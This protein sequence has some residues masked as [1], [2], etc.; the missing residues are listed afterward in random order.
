MSIFLLY[1]DDGPPGDLGEP[2]SQLKLSRVATTVRRSGRP[3]TKTV[4]VISDGIASDGIR[5]GTDPRSDALRRGVAFLVMSRLLKGFKPNLLFHIFRSDLDK[6][7]IDATSIIEVVAA[8]LMVNV[9][10]VQEPENVHSGAQRPGGV[11][12]LESPAPV[13]IASVAE[14]SRGTLGEMLRCIPYDALLTFGGRSAAVKL[15][16]AGPQKGRRR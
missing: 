12:E 16:Y 14:G 13:R 9:T 1:F 5:I 3:L 4:S 7:I 2:H 10:R 6:E 15:E 8:D 11:L